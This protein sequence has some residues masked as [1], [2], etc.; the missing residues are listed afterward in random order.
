MLLY[1]FVYMIMDLVRTIDLKRIRRDLLEDSVRNHIVPE[2]TSQPFWDVVNKQF[3]DSLDKATFQ[4]HLQHRVRATTATEPRAYA[5]VDETLERIVKDVKVKRKSFFE[6]MRTE[7]TGILCELYDQNPHHIIEDEVVSRLAIAV[8]SCGYTTTDLKNYGEVLMKQFNLY[9]HYFTLRETEKLLLPNTIKYVNGIIDKYFRRLVEI[10]QIKAVLHNNEQRLNGKPSVKPAVDYNAEIILL[11]AGKKDLEQKLVQAE[12]CGEDTFIMLY[13]VLSKK[14]YLTPEGA[15]KT[16]EVKLYVKNTDGKFSRIETIKDIITPQII[17]EIVQTHLDRLVAVRTVEKEVIR[18]VDVEP[19][20]YKDVK[21]KAAEL[22][23]TKK[24]H[25]ELLATYELVVSRSAELTY[26]NIDLLPLGKL[27]DTLEKIV[28]VEEGSF[29]TAAGKERLKIIVREYTTTFDCFKSLLIQHFSYDDSVAGATNGDNSNGIDKKPKSEFEKLD[30]LNDILANFRQYTSTLMTKY[31]SAKTDI[32]RYETVINDV[33]F[34]LAK[35]QL[36][37]DDFGRFSSAQRTER[38]KRITESVGVWRVYDLLGIFAEDDSQRTEYRKLTFGAAADKLRSLV[39]SAQ[40]IAVEM[41]E[42]NGQLQAEVEPLRDKSR[43]LESKLSETKV[44]VSEKEGRISTLRTEIATLGTEK[45]RIES[46]RARLA[47]ELPQLRRDYEAAVQRETELKQLVAEV[48]KDLLPIA[49]YANGVASLTDDQLPSALE[50]AIRLLSKNYRDIQ[51]RVTETLEPRIAALE[52]EVA[53]YEDDKNASIAQMRSLL[54]AHRLTDEKPESYYESL[55]DD[56]I[57][58]EFYATVPELK[59]SLTQSTQANANLT[60]RLEESTARFTELE[61]RVSTRR[62]V[63]YL[64]GMR[65]VLSN[66]TESENEKARYKTMQGDELLAELES[67]L[68]FANLDQEYTLLSALTGIEPEHL[69]TNDGESYVAPAELRSTIADNLSSLRQDYKGAVERLTQVDEDYIT[70]TAS[71]AAR[72]EDQY[73]LY[74]LLTE[75]RVDYLRTEG[76]VDYVKPDDLTKKIGD[77][78]V[79]LKLNY[80]EVQLNYDNACSEIMVMKNFIL[81][82]DLTEERVSKEAS[83][84]VDE[85]ITRVLTQDVLENLL[86]RALEETKCPV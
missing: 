15:K 37:R 12:V 51:Q 60:Q 86:D 42:A 69:K 43:G 75:K 80:A 5:I 34:N 18:N 9:D 19:F 33:L 66:A 64:N 27:I 22:D 36:E 10:P 76:N 58:T 2:R 38:L 47:A 62:K 56:A 82:G 39:S 72:V 40:T 63:S 28:R 35:D 65:K 79:S 74:S 55:A 61:G 17:G 29:R 53:K 50:G 7:V 85:I 57:A 41:M 3:F 14:G 26:E 6:T 52:K 48:Y 32:E 13:N 31:C 4:D 77:T 49:G 46:A 67:K 25:Q 45:D 30:S 8:E 11:K 23:A 78:I 16:T 84:Q 59:E 20:D 54:T 1:F 73:S 71:L 68:R 81:S 70:A 21:A 44:E 24:A 83:K